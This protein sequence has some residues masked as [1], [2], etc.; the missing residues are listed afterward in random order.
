M[1]I[2]F[3]YSN[4]GKSQ[5]IHRKPGTPAWRPGTFLAPLAPGY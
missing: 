5:D 4:L 2:I 1:K 3:Y